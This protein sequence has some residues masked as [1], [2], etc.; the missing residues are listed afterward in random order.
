MQTRLEL[1]ASWMLDVG[2]PAVPSGVCS[3]EMHTHTKNGPP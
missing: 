3:F 1:S 2:D